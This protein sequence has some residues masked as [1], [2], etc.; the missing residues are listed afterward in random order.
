MQR[1]KRHRLEIDRPD[2]ECV[3]NTLNCA[4]NIKLR[5]WKRKEQSK[6]QYAIFQPQT[7]QRVTKSAK[8]LSV[9]VPELH[10]NHSLDCVSTAN[11]APKW[12]VK[13]HWNFKKKKQPET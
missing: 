4:N 6:R 9:N 10:K 7:R 2:E 11:I 5:Q 3:K 13:Q 8:R 1:C 12:L